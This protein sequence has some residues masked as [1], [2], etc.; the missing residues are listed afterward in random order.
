VML[1]FSSAEDTWSTSRTSDGNYSFALVPFVQMDAFP[2]GW[3]ADQ[4]HL[5]ASGMSMR[6]SS[7]SGETYCLRNGSFS[8]EIGH[9]EC[10]G[11]LTRSVG[12]LNCD[13]QLQEHSTRAGAPVAKPAAFS[14]VNF[15][16]R[17]RSVPA[18][19]VLFADGTWTGTSSGPAS[20]S[21]APAK[22]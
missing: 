14:P 2:R 11:T 8:G 3:I 10:Q 6:L 13:E 1:E 15:G 17:S 5:A 9:L 16:L 18:T 22:R 7:P 19:V 4:L 12:E 20:P 21:A